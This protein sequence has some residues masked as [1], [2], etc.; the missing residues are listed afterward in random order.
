VVY[1]QNNGVSG[2][3]TA[4][5]AQ[6]PLNITPIGGGTPYNLYT[7]NFLGPVDTNGAYFYNLP[8]ATVLTAVLTAFVEVSPVAKDSTAPLA[9]ECCPFDPLAIELMARVTQTMAVGDMV[10][11]NANGD[12]FRKICNILADVAEPIGQA[13]G[14]FVPG[15]AMVGSTIAK[16]AR[17]GAQLKLS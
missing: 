14:C 2:S 17:F 7:A 1:V 5:L 13:I 11:N 10:K 8:N 12:W 4:A 15:A 3:T 16:G 9:K 6:N